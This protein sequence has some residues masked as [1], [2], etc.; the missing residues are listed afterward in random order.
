MS[1]AQS[2]TLGLRSNVSAMLDKRVFR[3]NRLHLTREPTIHVGL[4]DDS[5][6][7]RRTAKRRA[8]TGLLQRIFPVPRKFFF[9]KAAH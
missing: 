3:F 1:G 8:T 4:G 7:L 5:C 9:S 2:V 6:E